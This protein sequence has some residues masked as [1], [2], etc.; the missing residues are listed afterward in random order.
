MASENIQKIEKK[1]PKNNRRI[2]TI[3]CAYSLTLLPL[4]N[5]FR[6][7]FRSPELNLYKFRNSDFFH[8]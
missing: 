7:L 6:H 8:V 3:V 1:L 2:E 5:I 4:L